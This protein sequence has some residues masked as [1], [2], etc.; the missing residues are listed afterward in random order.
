MKSLHGV[1]H[2]G[3]WI[4]FHGLPEFRHAYLQEVGMTQIS[5]DHDFLIYFISITNFKAYS[6]RDSKI[7]FMANKFSQIDKV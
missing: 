6:I 3:L 7:D 4:R 5:G 2:G 1:L